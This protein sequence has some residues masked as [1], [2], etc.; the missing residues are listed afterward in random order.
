M[1]HS[2]IIRRVTVALANYPHW[3]PFREVPC[4]RNTMFRT[5][6]KASV[7]GVTAMF[8]YNE[9]HVRTMLVY[10]ERRGGGEP[11]LFTMNDM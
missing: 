2:Y 3:T 9:R 11:C 4:R 8:V 1:F 6:G 10:N 7:C 5:G